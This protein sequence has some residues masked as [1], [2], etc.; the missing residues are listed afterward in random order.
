MSRIQ[1]PDDAFLKPYPDVYREFGFELWSLIY[2]QNAR[3]VA[4]RLNNPE[5]DDPL[6][7]ELPDGVKVRLDSRE[8]NP[9][10]IRKWAN[11]GKWLERHQK[12]FKELAPLFHERV[13]STISAATMEAAQYLREV[14]T[15]ESVDPKHR[16]VAANSILDRGGHLAFVRPSDNTRPVGPTRDYGESLAGQTTEEL[17]RRVLGLPP[18]DPPSE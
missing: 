17:M 9:R 13:I 15:D 3:K 8:I 2:D 5:E 11:D 7:E 12:R 6:W 14:I 1:S 18:G 16:I 10:T 4:D